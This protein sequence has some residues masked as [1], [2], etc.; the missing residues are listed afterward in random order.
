MSRIV[1]TILAVIGECAPDV[2]ADIHN[3]GIYLSGGV[4][5][6]VGIEEFMSKILEIPVVV[7]DQPE[8]TVIL[9]A[10]KLLNDSVLY[11]EVVS[12]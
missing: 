5:Q 12:E 9:G 7:L 2:V 10:G 8:N 11:A 6:L 1:A 4:S 3:K